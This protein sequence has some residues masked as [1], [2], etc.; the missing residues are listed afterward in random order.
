MRKTAKLVTALTIMSTGLVACNTNNE[1]MDKN[2]NDNT[3]PIGYYSNDKMNDRNRGGV[4][5][6]VDDTTRNKRDNNYG[7]NM[8]DYNKQNVNNRRDMN[9][10]NGDA[11]GNLADSITD[12]VSRIRNVEDCRTLVNGD[13]VIVAVDTDD[14]NNADVTN[15]VKKECSDIAAGKN[16]QVVTDENLFTRVRDIDDNLRSGAGMEDINADMEDLMDNIND[17]MKD[18]FNNR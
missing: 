17:S 4:T 15:E 11:N 3:Q 8:K 6:I 14:K 12:R 2:Y 7:T 13:N 5:D 10:F 1:A 16:V 18:M 9:I